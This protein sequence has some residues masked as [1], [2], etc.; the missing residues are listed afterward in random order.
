MEKG[1]HPVSGEP[2]YMVT[3]TEKI[4]IDVALEFMSTQCIGNT[5]LRSSECGVING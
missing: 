5:P 1:F 3:E 2:I 4:I